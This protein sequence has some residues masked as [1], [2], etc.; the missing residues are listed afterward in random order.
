MLYMVIR[1]N[2]YER[3]QA[4]SLYKEFVVEIVD[5]IPIPIGTF[6]MSIAAMMVSSFDGGSKTYFLNKIVDR[7]KSIIK[8]SKCLP[9]WNDSLN[10]LEQIDDVQI[11]EV[12]NGIY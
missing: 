3:N 10:W 11:T 1:A 6:K 7:Y 9:A 4:A 8:H 5:P 12:N 2:I